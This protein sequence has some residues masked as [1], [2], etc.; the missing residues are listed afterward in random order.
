MDK[1]NDSIEELKI[2]LDYSD[3]VLESSPEQGSAKRLERESSRKK[4]AKLLVQKGKL[5]KEAGIPKLVNQSP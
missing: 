1:V 2:V 3:P 5:E 4:L